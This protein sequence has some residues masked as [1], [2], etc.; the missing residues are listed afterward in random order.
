MPL[1]L[2]AKPNGAV[3]NLNCSYCYYLEKEQLYP[4]RKHYRMSDELL[5]KYIESYILS[6]PTPHV[7]FTWHGGETLLRDLSFYKKAITLQKKY[8]HGRQIENSLQTN[9]ILLSEDWCRFFKENNFLIG[10]SIDGP[11]DCHDIYRRNRGGVATFKQ[12]MRGIELLQRYGVEYNTLSVIHDYNA[13]RPLEV[14]RFL[15]GIGSHYMQFSPIVERI[16]DHGSLLSV[17]SSEPGTLGPWNVSPKDFGTFYTTIFDEWVRFDVGTYFVQ[18]FDATLANWVGASPGVC[19]YAEECGHAAVMEFNGDVYSC[20]HF[21]F[22]EYKLGNIY[23]DTLLGMMLSDRQLK[24]GKMKKERLPEQ[25]KK[26]P[27]L[28]LCNGECPKNRISCDSLGNP[29]LNYLCEG[30]RMF[31]EYVAPYMDC[32]ARLLAEERSPAFVMNWIRGENIWSHG[33]GSD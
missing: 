11:E 19:I 2:M 27:Y 9:G 18:L 5:E 13:R 20:D 25:C 14:Y 17:T 30:Y 33:N 6:Q 8:A 1:Y 16:S 21:V 4:N 15:K 23:K 7:L 10:I 31:F 24:F 29:G 12:V 26:C 32:M 22:P 3:C 28:K